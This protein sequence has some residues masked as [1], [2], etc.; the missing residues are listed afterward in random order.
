MAISQ[1]ALGR[2]W[3]G[4]REGINIYDGVKITSFKGEIANGKSQ[5]IWIGNEISYIVKGENAD[6]N[7][8]FF[9]SDFSLYSFDIRTNFFTQIE[10]QK[11]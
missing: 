6:W 8:I 9:I 5:K 3:F 2:M 10:T 4:T 1:D 11:M 7:K